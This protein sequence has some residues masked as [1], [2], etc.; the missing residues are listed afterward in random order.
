MCNNW[1]C[2]RQKKKSSFSDCFKARPLIYTQ[3]TELV[4]KLLSPARQRVSD[5][6]HRPSSSRRENYP[7]LLYRSI[8]TSELLNSAINLALTPGRRIFPHS[9]CRRLSNSFPPGRFVASFSM[10]ERERGV[11]E[12]RVKSNLPCLLAH[13]NRLNAP[14]VAGH[15]TTQTRA[16]S[17][18]APS[19]PPPSRRRCHRRIVLAHAHDHERVQRRLYASYSSHSPPPPL[20]THIYAVS[21]R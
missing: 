9:T 7:A 6:H 21:T 19:P 16:A 18:L 3:F 11:F 4:H 15:Y 20:F 12:H 2:L 8:L 17:P 1:K 5:H 14:S 13:I 10:R